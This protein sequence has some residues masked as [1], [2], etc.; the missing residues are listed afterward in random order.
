MCKNYDTATLTNS[1]NGRFKR[2]GFNGWDSIS[3]TII[4]VMKSDDVN[5]TSYNM[6]I[7]T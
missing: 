6:Q 3:S 5:S 1:N 4:Q 7:I 2:Y